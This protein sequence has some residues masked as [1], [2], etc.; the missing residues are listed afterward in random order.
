MLANLPLLVTWYLIQYA[1]V[2]LAVELGLTDAEIHYLMHGRHEG[3]TGNPLFNPEHYLENNPDVAQAV[4]AGTTTAQDHF[5]EHGAAEGRSPNAL[6]NEAFYLQQNPDVAQAIASGQV[7][8]ASEHFINYGH[9]EARAINPGID[10][11]KYLSANPDV[12]DEL[13]QNGLSPLEHLMTYGVNEGRDLGNGVTLADFKDDPAF[14]SALEQGD[15]QAALGRVEQVAPFIPTFQRP[16]GWAPPANLAI[17]VDFIPAE[18]SGLKL[19]IP[20]EITVPA[21]VSLPSTVFLNPTP[22]TPADDTPATSFSVSLTDGTL[23]YG[24]NAQ[25]QITFEIHGENVLFFRSGVQATSATSVPLADIT[26][27]HGETLYLNHNVNGLSVTQASTLVAGDPILI[28]LNG[29]TYGVVD[30]ATNILGKISDTVITSAASVATSDADPVDISLSQH[31][32]F[33]DENVSITNGF[34][35]A[36]S[37]AAA[38]GKDFSTGWDGIRGVKLTGS[39]GGQTVTGSNFDD[40]IAGG[41]GADLIHTKDGSDIITQKLAGDSGAF[42]LGNDT[43]NSVPTSLFDILY[44]ISTTDQISL[45]MYTSAAATTADNIVSTNV[46]S[47]L[48]VAST[49]G[50][51]LLGNT[52]LFIRGTYDSADKTFSGTNLEN[53]A[54]LIYD[55]HPTADSVQHEAI[56][57]IGAGQYSLTVSEDA[58]LS[59]GPPAG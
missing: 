49:E 32:S 26:S 48:T 13:E 3:R 21:G 11:G 34:Y 45:A 57:L 39:D 20:D 25:G 16:D 55:S 47:A 17:P 9:R 35:I 31:T 58:V 2:R 33:T 4:E 19:S 24:G 5:A 15:V 14:K 27:T 7:Q 36:D 42:I 30:S 38:N 40:E 12:T 29:K 51:S 52:V 37:I 46:S 59:F 44:D 56:V 22:I 43:T 10:L 8:S 53:D 50:P 6:F 18:G 28:D 1:D 23:N 54:L 41:A